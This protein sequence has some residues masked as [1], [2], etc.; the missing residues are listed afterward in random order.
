MSGS[1]LSRYEFQQWFLALFF[2]FAFFHCLAKIP[3]EI[4]NCL[5]YRSPVTVWVFAVEFFLSLAT[6]DRIA[7]PTVA[8][9]V[10]SAF[11]PGLGKFFFS[12]LLLESQ[13]YS[14]IMSVSASIL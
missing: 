13:D 4:L 1:H 12:F 3:L 7:L 8:S 6:R 10:S 5:S 14:R 2:A 11:R 9:L